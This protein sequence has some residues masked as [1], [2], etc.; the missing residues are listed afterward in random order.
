MPQ[1]ARE[2][3]VGVPASPPL[4]AETTESFPE[5]SCWRGEKQTEKP[6]PEA[7]WKTLVFWQSQRG[8]NNSLS[9][10]ETRGTQEKDQKGLVS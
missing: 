10:R 2:V 1:G 6:E 7:W 4:R 5:S 3:T 9:P 8:K